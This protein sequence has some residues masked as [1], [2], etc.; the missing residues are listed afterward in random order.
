MTCALSE[1]S[2]QPGH[3]PSLIRVL[4]V[5]MKKPR[6]LSYLL[7]AQRKLWSDW[8]DAQTHLNPR[9]A[10]WSFCWFCHAVAHIKWI[11]KILIWLRSCQVIVPQFI[12]SL[13]ILIEVKSVR[14]QKQLAGHEA[15]IWISS[16]IHYW[17]KKKKKA[18]V[19]QTKIWLNRDMT[20][21]TKWV[22]AQR[23]LR[24]AW[25]SAQSDQS[26]RCPHEETL[27]P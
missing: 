7:S 11:R 26:L 10:H 14:S 20:K 16:L 9:C 22:C 24:S 8:A 6:V 19:N 13:W 17:Q 18:T 4:A 2:D 1:D 3:P 12:K 21:S 5:R 23:R 15:V 25:A 27:G